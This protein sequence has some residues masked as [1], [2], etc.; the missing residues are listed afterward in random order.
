MMNV[1]LQPVAVDISAISLDD[2]FK[3]SSF[4]EDRL[5]HSIKKNGI[6]NPPILLKKDQGF[7]VLL[8][9]NRIEAARRL[10]KDTVGALIYEEI[11]YEIMKQEYLSKEYYGEISGI[12]RIRICLFFKSHNR[13]D[14]Y[15]E[16]SVLFAFDHDLLLSQEFDRIQ[17]DP[18]LVEYFV[19]RKISAKLIFQIVQMDR[20]LQR[21][22][23]LIL[24]KFEP[25]TNILKL[26]LSRFEDLK[27]RGFSKD[28]YEMLVEKLEFAENGES[29]Y[30]D[31]ELLRYPEYNRLYKASEECRAQA[32]SEGIELKF[33]PYFEGGW[34]DCVV[35]IK[36]GDSRKTIEKKIENFSN[37]D[38]ERLK[39]IIS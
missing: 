10:G 29:F 18:V 21:L 13:D 20:L 17:S 32:G 12:H 3:F 8:G 33:P 38:F 30:H 36:S 2:T 14:L 26:L 11:P 37:L 1:T 24:K 15:E 27:Q 19:K 28:N 6:L 22:L 35:R 39:S 23:I 25:K 34:C 7:V 16:L 5:L 9:H 31:V 4:F